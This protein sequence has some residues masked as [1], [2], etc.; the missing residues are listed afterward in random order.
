MEIWLGFQP[1]RCVSRKAPVAFKILF[2][3]IQ[4]A[5]S[6]GLG[7]TY[8]AA[9]TSAKETQIQASCCLSSE[10]YSVWHLCTSLSS[11]RR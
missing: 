8:L 4:L 1:S 6:H 3:K 2:L 7:D 11:S 5:L 9:S 10:V